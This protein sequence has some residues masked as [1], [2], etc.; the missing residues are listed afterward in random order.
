MLSLVALLD[1]SPQACTAHIAGTRLG[2]E[3][4]L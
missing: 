2:R 3:T 4:L 1:A